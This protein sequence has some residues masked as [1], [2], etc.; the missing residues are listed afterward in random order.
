[1]TRMG[2]LPGPLD[3]VREFLAREGPQ[4][5]VADRGRELLYSH[6]PG[7]YLKRLS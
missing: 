1:M 5:W 7:G 4:R 3:A 6:H 2:P